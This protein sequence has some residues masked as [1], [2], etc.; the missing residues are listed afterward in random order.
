[1]AAKP[2]GRHEAPFVRWMA[3]PGFMIAW[4]FIATPALGSA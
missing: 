3:S 4:R 1:M 2:Y